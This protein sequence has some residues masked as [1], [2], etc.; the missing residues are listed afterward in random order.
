MKKLTN[1]IGSIFLGA[2]L[3]AGL[4]AYANNN[5]KPHYLEGYE[6]PDNA[7][8]KMIEFSKFWYMY[9]VSGADFFWN[10]PSL[11]VNDCMQEKI[12]I[13]GKDVQIYFTEYT[14]KD[15]GV[16]HIKKKEYVDFESV[17]KD[18]INQV[19]DA[20]DLAYEQWQGVDKEHQR[21]LEEDLEIEDLKKIKNKKV[22]GYDITY[23]DILGYFE[24][25]KSDF[26]PS[27]LYFG[28]MPM[29]VLGWAYLETDVVAYGEVSRQHD[30]IT[31]RPLV[32]AHE[33][34]HN[35]P[36]LQ[37]YPGMFAQ[38]AE[39][40][41]FMLQLS[42][43]ENPNNFLTHGYGVD[44]RKMS[45]ILFDLDAYVLRD[46]IIEKEYMNFRHLDKDAIKK[47]NKEI[48]VVSEEIQKTV[49]EE[50]YPEYLANTP[51]WTAATAFTRDDDIVFKVI[52]A[53]KYDPTNLYDP[54]GELDSV[55]YTKKWIA[56]HE[57]EIEEITEEAFQKQEN[58]NRN[59][60]YQLG[61]RS[62]FFNKIL[63]FET[64]F[65][66]TAKDF[67]FDSHES[68]AAYTI[69]LRNLFCK[70]VD[71]D[72]VEEY[73]VDYS[74]L[75]SE[76]II[77]I[78]EDYKEIFDYIDEA[79]WTEK[80]FNK[81]FERLATKGRVIEYMIDVLKAE[82]VY[83]EFSE[84]TGVDLEKSFSS[85]QYFDHDDGTYDIRRFIDFQE[86]EFDL[87]YLHKS[88]DWDVI[89]NFTQLF[90]Y[91]EKRKGGEWEINK[92][93]FE[94]TTYDLDGDHIGDYIEVYR[95][96]DNGRKEKNA[97]IRVFEEMYGDLAVVVVDD[98]R[99]GELGHGIPDKVIDKYLHDNVA[100]EFMTKEFIEENL[101][102]EIRKDEEEIERGKI[103]KVSLH[104]RTEPTWEKGNWSVPYPYLNEPFGLELSLDDGTIEWI[105]KDWG[106]VEEF[107]KIKHIPGLE[108]KD[109]S[110]ATTSS[111][112]RVL[113]DR[114]GE[115][116][117]VVL[118]ENIIE[119]IPY[120]IVYEDENGKYWEI[121]DRESGPIIYESKRRTSKE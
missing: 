89:E 40:F 5:E 95:I 84:L 49:R 57:S 21:I 77:A 37:G 85:N 75:S 47:F 31:G 80:H 23:G 32:L 102:P 71:K 92:E 55:E 64:S 16:W 121:E 44:V 43:L 120:K 26:A 112:H 24:L 2:G 46:E 17:R 87:E 97:A 117:T 118:A 116:T 6:S 27:N 79:D 108:N 88:K 11:A 74:S 58:Y 104:G 48:V 52:L 78:L 70:A 60:P 56:E 4:P 114:E 12:R 81:G 22:E 10:P 98:D 67:G 1:I 94:A 99:E 9:D 30:F 86:K 113:I 73:R 61:E 41:T 50:V 3:M 53:A 91:E 28:A 105:S 63:D 100:S 68:G 83:Q 115:A 107:Y 51:F 29:G 38:D 45:R 42:D 13:D 119:D 35:N 15:E 96:K 72:G 106:Y 90:S 69:A 19:K 101:F 14:Q 33:F 109:I 18:V 66:K 111:D 20:T 36:E 93:S 39:I 62:G 82:Q 103:A 110:Q 65:Y 25:D 76:Q 8:D 34:T 54:E 59:A 7:I